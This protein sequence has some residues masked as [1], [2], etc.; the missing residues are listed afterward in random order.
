MYCLKSKNQSENKTTKY[1]FK[2]ILW[3]FGCCGV[4]LALSSVRASSEDLKNQLRDQMNDL[5]QQINGYRAN[6]KGLQTQGKSLKGEISLLDSKIKSAE[7]EIRRSNLLVRQIGDDMADKNVALGQAELKMDREKEI[8]AEY[9]RSL[10]NLDQKNLLEVFLKSEKLSDF[11]EEINSLENVQAGVQESMA[12]IKNLKVDL[13]SD[14]QVL[15]DKKEELNQLKVLQEIQR[16]ALT[17]QEQEK[18]DLLKETKGQENNF[19][20]LLNKAQSDADSIRKQ[21]YML[22]G[23]GVSMTL[24]KAYQYAKKAGDLTGTRPA[25]LLAVL[26]KESSWG[27]KTGTGTWRVD[28]HKRDQQPFIQICKELNVD[29]DKMAVSKKPSYGWG[30]AMGPAQFLPAI[31]LSYE[32]QIAKLTGHNPPDPWNIEDAFTAAALKLSQGGA[33]A[34]NENAEWKAAQLYFAG[35]RWNNPAY[36]FYGDQVM[37]LAGVIQEQINIIE[38]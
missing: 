14:K 34:K 25:F 27:E 24:E 20:S 13:E 28:M 15:E 6:V 32:S 37:D 9:I 19:Q 22:E 11:F 7:L 4:F 8:L 2:N 29:P 5:Q 16:R 3:F 31:W 35:S 12:E 1:F 26:K 36:Y 21:L 30:G 23:V 10:H 17:A 33:I 18:N 38:K